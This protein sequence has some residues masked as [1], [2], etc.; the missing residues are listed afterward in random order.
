M[1]NKKCNRK[2]QTLEMQH[3]LLIFISWEHQGYFSKVQ[4]RFTGT[5]YLK[6]NNAEIPKLK[7]FRKSRYDQS[8][9]VRL[10]FWKITHI[11]SQTT[12]LRSLQT[13]NKSN[14]GHL[15]NYSSNYAISH[16][17]VRK[18]AILVICHYLVMGFLI[19]SIMQCLQFQN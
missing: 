15:L 2:G 9:K 16:L 18:K 11:K 3:L 14:F 12:V 17:M 5:L 19:F 13:L 7:L 4:P 1:S 6:S 8:I 10:Y